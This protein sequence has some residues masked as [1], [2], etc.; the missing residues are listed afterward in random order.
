M[1]RRTRLLASAI[2]YVA[3]FVILLGALALS[4]SGALDRYAGVR[5]A[6]ALLAQLEGR[7]PGGQRAGGSEGTPVVSGSPFLEGSSQTVAAAALLQRV[8]ASINKIG[9]SV[10]SSQ[11]ELQKDN[12]PDGWVGLIVS[13]EIDQASLQPLLYDLEAGMPFLFIEQLSVQA[14]QGSS[15]DARLRIVV[16][17][18]GQWEGRK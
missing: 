17:V 6:D 4:V 12:A 10:L 5:A 9:G 7:R 2:A 18:S 11:V 1:N 16:T 14:P 3:L 15:D 13:S 8:A